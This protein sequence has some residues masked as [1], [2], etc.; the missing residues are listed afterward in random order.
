MFSIVSARVDP[1]LAAI[2][3]QGG[4]LNLE[5]QIT[6]LGNTTSTLTVLSNATVEFFAVANTLSKVMV[7]NSGATVL[8]GSSANTFSGAVILATNSPLAVGNCTFNMASSSLTLSGVLS[9]QGNLIKTGASTLI[10]SGN[11]T[12][13]G[14]TQVRAGT[15]SL[16]GSGSILSSTNIILSSGATLNASLRTDLTLVITNNQTLQGSGT[17]TGILVARSGSKLSPGTNFVNTGTLVVSSN[18]TL[19]GN[20]IMKVNPATGANDAL[21]AYTLTYGGTLT[22]SNISA[23]PFAAGNSFR[24][25]AP[26]NYAGGFTSIVPAI[27][28]IGLA[29]DTNN[30]PVNGRLSVI[31]LHQPG[32]ADFALS[33]TNLVLHGTNG[34]PARPYRVLMST[35]AALALNQW[36]TISTN[37]L[38]AAG[39][40]NITCT[41]AVSQS[42]QQKFFTLLLQ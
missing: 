34:Y 23:S 31:A 15:F 2:N 22:I 27:P 11:N 18:I 40:F 1:N 12:Y 9:G 29:W 10:L 41:N 17:I 5:G 38:G 28:G 20:T 39:N 26:T 19:Q 30:L 7:L 16:S 36:A 42:D 32:I 35:N 21:R 13:K 24:L 4:T 14:T 8:N 3:V 33:G 37:I 6:G 25:F